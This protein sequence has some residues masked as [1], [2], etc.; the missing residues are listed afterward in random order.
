MVHSAIS[1]SAPVR[2]ASKGTDDKV[3]EIISADEEFRRKVDGLA[4]SAAEANT[5]I[6]YS[7]PKK[8]DSLPPDELAEFAR[9]E[10]KIYRDSLEELAS[11]VKVV[12]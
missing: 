1:P 9:N 8:V 10:I 12:K 6:R 2:E 7:V 3:R 4:Q 5:S 11:S